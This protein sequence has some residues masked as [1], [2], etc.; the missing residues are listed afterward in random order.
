LETLGDRTLLELSHAIAPKV[1]QFCSSYLHLL[2]LSDS[3]S[4]AELNGEEG[5][6]KAIAQLRKKLLFDKYSRLLL[7]MVAET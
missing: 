4:S 2:E 5:T 7:P 3:Q 6:G 1:S